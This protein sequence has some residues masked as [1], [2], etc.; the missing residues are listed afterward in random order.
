M[1]E[2]TFAVVFYFCTIERKEKKFLYF[3]SYLIQFFFV[4]SVVLNNQWKISSGSSKEAV[5]WSC[6]VKKMF[7]GVLTSKFTGKH[8]CENTR[9]YFLIK[10]QA[11]GCET[12]A[13]VFPCE[14]CEIFKNT[15][16][17]RT[18]PVTASASKICMRLFEK[19]LSNVVVKIKR[20]ILN[21]DNRIVDSSYL[22]FLCHYLTII[23]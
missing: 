11:K 19:M 18:P 16:F 10:L 23:F 9:V 12:L 15:C 7:L 8:L 1:S 22:L 14:F 21:L 2:L 6:S 20:S 13:Q 3:D 5:V 17:Y 4:T